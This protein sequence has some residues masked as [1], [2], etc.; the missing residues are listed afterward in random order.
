MT[1]ITTAQKVVMI[2]VSV[3]VVVVVVVVVMV[4]VVVIVV[5]CGV[6]VLSPG[7]TGLAQARLPFF[8]L[9]LFEI[10]WNNEF[11]RKK[12][13]PANIFRPTIF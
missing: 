11:L 12:N 4:V 10:S 13:C 5:V 3:V 6:G 8:H 9:E 1:K 2:V 7:S